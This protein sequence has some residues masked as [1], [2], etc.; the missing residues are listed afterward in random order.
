MEK[1][2]MMSLFA[3][4]CSVLLLAGCDTNTKKDKDEKK[5]ATE[6]IKCV[7]RQEESDMITIGETVF[8]YDKDKEK[9]VSGTMDMKMD[10][11][12]ALKEMN[13][14][15]KEQTESLMKS[16][17]SGMCTTFEE[18]GYTDCEANFDSG[19]FDMTMKFDMKKLDE[20]TDGDINVDMS[21]DE[22]K[23]YFERTDGTKCT[24][25]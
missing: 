4:G 1:K 16:M 6:S 5:V 25:E 24:I 11:S 21:L 2:K 3:L 20:I 10:Y 22:L 15:Q 18:E 17:F 23:E 13:D 14:E 7:V 8:V 9:L 19:K 12:A